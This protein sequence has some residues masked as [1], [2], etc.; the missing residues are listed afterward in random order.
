MMSVL[1]AKE[2][3]KGHQVSDLFKH[4]KKVQAWISAQKDSAYYHHESYK[5]WYFDDFIEYAAKQV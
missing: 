1:F 5:H 2:A 4:W 3:K